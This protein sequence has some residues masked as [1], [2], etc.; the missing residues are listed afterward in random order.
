MHRPLINPETSVSRSSALVSVS[1][2]LIALIGAGQALLLALIVGEGSRT[3]AFFAAYSVYLIAALLGASLRSS[4]VP[5]FG[6]VNEE[7]PLREQAA[8]LLSRIL[9]I[10][11]LVL[12]VL[13]LVSPVLGQLMTLGLPSDARWTAVFT[14]LILAPAAYCQVHTA[15]LS[16]ALSAARRFSFSA[17]LYVIA[18]AFGLGCSALLLELI[19]VVGAAL[20][21]LAGAVV[22]AAGHSVYLA[23]FGIRPV[24]RLRFLRDRAQRSLATFL[25]AGA[26]LGLALQID[27]ALGLSALSSDTGAITAYSYAFFLIWMMLTVSSSPLSLVTMPDLVGRV[28]ERGM[29]A[30]EEQLERVAPYAFAVLAPMLMGYTAFGKPLLKTLFDSSLSDDTIDLVYQ[31]GLVLEGLAIPTALLFLVGA[32]TLALGRANRFLAVGAASIALQ[33]VLVISLSTFGPLAVAGGHA[34]TCLVTAVLLLVATY[35]PRW[36]AVAGRALGNSAPAIALTVVF[37]L[38]RLPLGD[39]PDLAPA[40][41]GLVVATAAYCALAVV[42]WPSVST[43][44]VDLVRRARQPA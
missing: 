11:V 17:V 14:L 22:L 5:L 15:A 26:A 6:P 12:L 32:V 25:V 24:P 37:P 10:G 39:E 2:L 27:L 35:G 20:G 21:L 9:V 8:E 36:P 18:G 29:A 13:V 34:A 28:A 33:A 19:G 31:I 30:A 3:D 1:L 40:V 41:A 44:F 42:L 43:A 16:A 38:A 7:G 23:R 4:V